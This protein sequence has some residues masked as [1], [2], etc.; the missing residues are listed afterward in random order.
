MPGSMRPLLS[1][2][3]VIVMVEEVS[4]TLAENKK[5]FDVLRMEDSFVRKTG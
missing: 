2:D 4:K 1:T 5:I 3:G